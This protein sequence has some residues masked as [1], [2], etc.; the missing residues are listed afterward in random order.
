MI[1]SSRVPQ[2]WVFVPKSV[3][4]GLAAYCPCQDARVAVPY[5]ALSIKSL[6][7]KVMNDQPDDE[8]SKIPHL[9]RTAM[10]GD[11]P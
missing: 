2:H 5:R 8:T 10:V 11:K 9:R 6:A 1:L 7:V 3:R 4:I